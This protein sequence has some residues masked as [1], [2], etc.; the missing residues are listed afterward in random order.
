MLVI[1]WFVCRP[2]MTVTVERAFN[3]LQYFCINV[4]CYSCRMILFAAEPRF[5]CACV[6]IQAPVAFVPFQSTFLWSLV[7]RSCLIT[8]QQSGKQWFY[9][10][11]A[12]VEF[13][14]MVLQRVVLILFR[15]CY[16]SSTVT[17]YTSDHTFWHIEELLLLSSCVFCNRPFAFPRCD[18]W[19]T[20][21]V[22]GYSWTYVALNLR[23]GLSS[24]VFYFVTNCP[25]LLPD[26]ITLSN[27]RVCIINHGLVIPFTWE[28]VCPLAYFVF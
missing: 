13:P 19:V 6:V 14:K 25:S 10:I 12:C 16:F 4:T 7:V 8:N 24:C 18:T 23:A 20:L 26:L 21:S 27:S 3:I 28:Q 11:P 2:D 9:H 15:C 1:W 17:E 22:Y 5:Y